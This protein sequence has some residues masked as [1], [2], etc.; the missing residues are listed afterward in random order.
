MTHKRTY[1]IRLC[2]LVLLLFA[3]AGVRAQTAR[4]TI[5]VY[6]AFNEA[7]LSRQAVT[8][9]DSLRYDEILNPGQQLLII[10]YAD[11][12][13][14]GGYNDTL[15]RKRAAAT[16]NYLLTLGFGETN[17]QLCIG[18]GK[19]LR[20][21]LKAGRDGYAPDRR[22]DI[23]VLKKNRKQVQ[24]TLAEKVTPRLP[25]EIHFA[26][27]K[28]DIAAYTPEETFKLENLYFPSNKHYLERGSETVLDTLVL[29]LKNHPRM[30]IRVEGHICC[31]TELPDAYDDDTHTYNLSVN[32]AK[33]I[34]NYL[35]QN[36]IPATHITYAGFGRRMPVE[37]V[38][39]T[40]EQA[41]RN[42]RVEI[43][44]LSK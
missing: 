13:G 23:V 14:S 7:A 30:R 15:S 38:E 5:P 6:F 10:G 16:K 11:F 39:N 44:V 27:L 29:I 24:T 32:R 18:K 2:T 31:V 19:V 36:G 22:V 8:M 26:A 42:R 41:R 4:D 21:G 37:P 35:I 20:P 9:L 1:A 33:F 34:R 25:E 40:E 28:K 17:V 43:R 12:V 3:A